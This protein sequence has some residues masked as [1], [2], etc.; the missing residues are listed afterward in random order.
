[1]LLTDSLTRKQRCSGPWGPELAATE[2]ISPESVYL[3]FMLAVGGKMFQVP[4][5]VWVLNTQEGKRFKPKCGQESSFVL[6]WH[7]FI[8]LPYCCLDWRQRKTDNKGQYV[9][10]SMCSDKL[11]NRN[12]MYATLHRFFFLVGNSMYSWCWI[13]E[14]A[15]SGW[16]RESAY[17]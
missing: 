10:F 2:R 13:E 3:R 16:G 4:A 7:C 15:C 17:C 11:R 8:H 12:F 9:F 5:A 6:G 1:M 14:R